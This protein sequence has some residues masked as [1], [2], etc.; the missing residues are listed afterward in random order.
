MIALI[1]QTIVLVLNIIIEILIFLIP[2]IYFNHLFIV[3]SFIWQVLLSFLIF[4]FLSIF[5][6]H[7]HFIHLLLSLYFLERLKDWVHF[8]NQ[9]FLLRD[10]NRDFS[11]WKSSY[12]QIYR[13]IVCM[14]WELSV[15]D[16]LHLD[17]NCR[18]IVKMNQF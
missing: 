11:H 4:K 3:F 6:H 17:A 1:I 10:P 18:L 5:F 15:R 8:V 14:R 2:L 12:F 13:R 16:I 9:N 7:L